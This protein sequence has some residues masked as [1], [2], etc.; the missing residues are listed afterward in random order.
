[1]S[2]S[3]LGQQLLAYLDGELSPEEARQVDV[4]VAQCPQC[5]AELAELRTLGQG[6]D[7]TLD[8]VLSPVKLSREADD[9]IRAVLRQRLERRERAGW[10]WRIWGQ[11]MRVAQAALAIM[12]LVFSF[13]TYRVLSLPPP[14]ATQEV[15]VF[16]ESRLAPGS[17][18]ALRVIVRTAAGAAPA[19]SALTSA[20][21]PVVGARVIISLLTESGVPAPLYAGETD[22]LGTVNAAFTVPELPEGQADLVIETSSAAGE[23]R[24]ERSVEIARAYKIYIM[25]D[26]PAYRPGQ[27]F[28]MRAFVLDS[29][30]LRPVSGEDLRWRVTGASGET[31]CR[32][33]LPLSDYGISTWQCDLSPEAHEGTYVLSAALGDTTTER[34]VRVEDYDLPAFKVVVT[35]DRSYYAPG[36]PLAVT[37][38]A[39][40][41]FGM[42]VGDGDAIL[43]VYEQTADGRLVVQSRGVTDAQGHAVL[44]VDLP[45][46]LDDGQ[47]VL[48]AQIVDSP[49]QVAGIR[50]VVPVHGTPLLVRAMPESGVLKPGVENDVFV[51]TTTPDGRS[52]VAELTVT[53]DGERYEL[54]TDAFGL[55]LLQ[56]IPS[57]DTELAVEARDAVGNEVRTTVYLLADVAT[58]ALLLHTA[59]AIYEVGETLR[60]TALVPGDSAGPV[61]LD[62]VQ[63]GRM[64]AALSTP[65][66]DGAAIFTLDLDAE[67]AGALELRATTVPVQGG[68]L[69]DTRLVVVDPPRALEVTIDADRDRYMP[70]DVA[71]LAIE[72]TGGVETGG[73]P[74]PAVLGISVVDASVYA[75]D[76]L[77]ANFARAYILINEEMLARRDQ[78]SGVELPSLLDGLDGTQ[79]A[80][81]LV[82]QA[83]WAGAPVA[84][85]SLRAQAVLTP[86]DAA[87]TSR[88]RLA[89][90][91]HGVLVLLPFVVIAA[92]VQHLRLTGLLSAALKR[93]AIA[94]GVLVLLAPVLIV[95]LVIGWLLPVLGAVLFF[96]ALG[97]A[98]VLLGVLF[99]YG[100]RRRRAQV[101]FFAALVLAYLVLAGLTLGLASSG[102]ETGVGT[103]ILLAATFLLLILATLF[104]GQALLVERALGV[105]WATTALAL[106][107]AILAVTAP[108]VPGLRSDLAIAVGNPALYVGPLGWLSGCG[109]SMEAP[110]TA[111]TEAAEEPTEA[112]LDA[113][114]TWVLP[115]ATPLSTPAPEATAPAEPTLPAE[116]Y[117]LRHIFPETLY[118]DPDAKT[119]AQGQLLLDLPLAD[120]LTTWQVTA[121]ASTLD[122]AI[123]AATLPLVVSQDLVLDVSSADEAAVGEAI[124]I[125]LSVYNTSDMAE[126]VMWELPVDEGFVTL[127]APALLTVPAKSGAGATWVIRPERAGSLSL[128]IAAMGE[129]S[130][131]RVL[132]EL[133]IAR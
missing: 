15:L 34:A 47:L 127:E 122:G 44:K 20:I 12:L 79:A 3:H 49:G 42:P 119:D 125:T 2:E 116:P 73:G 22:H 5:A 126:L 85:A 88:Q 37:V 64:V 130:G 111:E 98:L 18:G 94:L 60:A 59:K 113:E 33:A 92:V 128:E 55:A 83:A 46:D 43:R 8:T 10:L 77:P 25:A 93:V 120:S 115:T 101:R 50:Q 133:E 41:F 82:A 31:L 24:I 28:Q 11:R 56:L 87:A 6:L 78:I 86:V 68:P 91:L 63:D 117:P 70:G 65:V 112:P 108:A 74:V 23:E 104:E 57:G 16:G 61:Y 7:Q 30:N 80:Q 121:L 84:D 17:Q 109:V 72:A 58:Q 103:L 100:W 19:S 35:A 107:L 45:V 106:L 40:Y 131:D 102:A 4:H 89:G 9:R 75:L 32:D 48:E 1:M 36:E 39:S 27:T 69:Q 13:G 67:F 90:W 97:V 132:V 21:S 96:I 76:S 38:E 71:H 29:T 62:V 110:T 54:R 66:E 51:M 52:A 123:G 26:K 129:R 118:W 99:A 114:P 105:G 53:A 14:V 124:T 95:G 81:D